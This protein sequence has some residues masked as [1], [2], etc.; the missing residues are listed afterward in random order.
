MT[1]TVLSSLSSRFLDIRGEIPKL[2][3]IFSMLSKK[4]KRKVFQVTLVQAFLAILDLL[5][6]AFIGLFISLSSTTLTSQANNKLVETV[7]KILTLDKVSFEMQVLALGLISAVLLIS[8]TV[9]S[10]YF[11]RRILVFLQ[12]QSEIIT[13][14]NFCNLLKLSPHEVRMFP[15]N[16]LFYAYMIGIQVSVVGTISP[17]SFLFIDLV[18]TVLIVSLLFIADA[19]LAMVIVLIFGILALVLH[20]KLTKVSR[21]H[22]GRVAE[23]MVKTNDL[24]H[25]IL[26]AFKELKIRNQLENYVPKLQS[27]Q[28]DLTQSR[29]TLSFMPFFSK[30]A[31]EIGI[32]ISGILVS[33]VK[34]YFDSAVGAISTLSVFLAA[35]FRLAPASTKCQCPCKKPCTG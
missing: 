25:E 10:M 11:S 7:L 23:N 33:S 34:I 20:N 1:N 8:K 35:T 32:V 29:S 19:W 9:L 26:G 13:L 15:A 4:G 17:L 12:K 2:I 16:E 18:L 14:D 31:L 6:I 21:L 5:A 30:Y 24:V 3:Q 22:G 27:I 28:G